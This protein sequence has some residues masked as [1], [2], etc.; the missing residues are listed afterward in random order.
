M[1]LALLKYCVFGS[2]DAFAILF[3]RYCILYFALVLGPAFE[4]K[5]DN[6]RL[7]DEVRK[8]R[9][10]WDSTMQFCARKDVG[11]LQWQEVANKMDMDG[12]Q[13]E[14]SYMFGLFYF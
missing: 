11:A 2:P 5:L 6:F 7:I 13:N 3:T 4:M 1:L 14:S 10:L 8:R 9:A 12:E